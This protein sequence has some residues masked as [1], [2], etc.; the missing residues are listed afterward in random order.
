MVEQFMEVRCNPV[1]SF[2]TFKNYYF[3]LQFLYNLKT[4]F[5]LKLRVSVYIISSIE[6]CAVIR[7]YF[8][9]Q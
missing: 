6:K 9:Y 1:V 4:V 5:F 3:G 8:K 2:N 7:H